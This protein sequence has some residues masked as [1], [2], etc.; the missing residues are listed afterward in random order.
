L[1]AAFRLGRRMEKVGQQ[2]R[3]RPVLLNRPF[4]VAAPR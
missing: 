3:K 4:F 1:M 2:E